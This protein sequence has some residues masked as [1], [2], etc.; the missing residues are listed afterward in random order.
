MLGYSAST[1]FP[2]TPDALQT[3]NFGNTDATLCKLSANGSSLLYSTYIGG[4][5]DD[6]DPRGNN[7]I[8]FG[9]CRIY[10]GVTSPS[11]D[12]PLTK[13]AV[14][15]S[16]ANGGIAQA[17]LMSFANPPDITSYTVTPTSQAITCG[18]KPAAIIAGT[19]T[20]VVPDVIRN[21]TVYSS[22]FNTANA[23]PNYTTAIA[24]GATSYQWQL[25][26]DA[27]ATWTNI[28]GASAK[29]LSQYK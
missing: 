14:T 4:A 6:F 2:V 20:Y 3:V 9:A 23:Y 18:S 13:G 27:Q 10:L 29:T 8:K 16:V 15:T 22:T 12:Y 17:L 5:G 26:V 1:N 19:V 7:A 11:D 24:S 25:S 28:A 21:T